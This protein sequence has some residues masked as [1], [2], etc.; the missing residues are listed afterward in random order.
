M[1]QYQRRN[2]PKSSHI[3]HI[4]NVI[5]QVRIDNVLH[6]VANPL[7]IFLHNRAQANDAVAGVVVRSHLILHRFCNLL[8]H[9]QI[10]VRIV[11]PL[12]RIAVLV[13]QDE[14]LSDD[15]L[16]YQL[17]AIL[18]ERRS[19]DRGVLLFLVDQVVEI[20]GDVLVARVT[21]MAQ[22]RYEGLGE[23]L[24]GFLVD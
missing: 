20:F 15:P 5:I 6:L 10:L 21:P 13:L 23:A 17:E 7:P 4:L 1:H 16:H 3:V 12:N 22:F 24:G 2:N 8:T 11:H 19:R 9:F 18:V 14:L